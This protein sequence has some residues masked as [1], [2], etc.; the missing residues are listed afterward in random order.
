MA[1]RNVLQKTGE[2]VAWG[3]LTSLDIY[4]CDPQIIRDTNKIRQF[5]TELCELIDMK[6]FGECMVV[7]FG[8]NERIEGYSMIQLIETSLISGHFANK[9]NAAYIDVFSCKPYDSQQVVSFA[10]KYFH[11][12]SIT[13][14]VIPRH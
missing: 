7:H 4:G 11:G 3:V 6:R 1:M 8:E 9:T 5:V 10:K 2:A 13:V 14:H 12:E